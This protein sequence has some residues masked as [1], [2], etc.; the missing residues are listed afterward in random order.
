MLQTSLWRANQ[1]VCAW[2]AY[3]LARSEPEPCA[4]VWPWRSS[5]APSRLPRAAPLHVPRAK[6]D[7][8]DGLGRYEGVA[9]NRGGL[10]AACQS[11]VFACV[12]AGAVD[13]RKVHHPAAPRWACESLRPPT[14]PDQSACSARCKTD[15]RG[16]VV[17]T[18]WGRHS[19]GKLPVWLGA[20]RK[21]LG[22]VS[23]MLLA[24]AHSVNSNVASS[25][26]ACKCPSSWGRIRRTETIRRL[27][28]I[29]GM[30]FCAG[31]MRRRSNWKVR[32]EG[33][34]C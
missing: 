8:L 10:S 13:R 23:W 7:C 6:M 4:L 26:D 20:K 33:K 15:A 32:P 31:S 24:Q 27:P 18:H 14:L 2:L 16:C 30:Q 22:V 5:P 17:R 21:G 25:D 11:G 3:W 12:S 29:S 28:L 34:F 9:I 1:A 19:L